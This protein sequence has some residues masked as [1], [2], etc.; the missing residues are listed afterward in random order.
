MLLN[1][2]QIVFIYRGV[3]GIPMKH[4]GISSG[5]RWCSLSMKLQIFK[6]MCEREKIKMSNIFGEYKCTRCGSSVK[7]TWMLPDGKFE[8]LTDCNKFADCR[9][10]K[11]G[12][13]YEVSV[14]CP[15]CKDMVCFDYS[16][17][18]AYIGGKG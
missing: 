3:I 1:W 12:S 17:D 18:G 11:V 4:H 13:K 10:S 6:M 8:S 9:H 16:L 15:N 14:W 5:T 7:Y 2:Q